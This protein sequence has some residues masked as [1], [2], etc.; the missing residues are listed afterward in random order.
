[1]NAFVHTVTGVLKAFKITLHGPKK[2]ISSTESFIF[3]LP[4][5]N[6]EIFK[7]INT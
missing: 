6:F 3:Q 1:M 4:D 7:E 2:L 5:V